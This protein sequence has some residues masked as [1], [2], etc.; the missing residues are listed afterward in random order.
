MTTSTP[1]YTW[2]SVLAMVSAPTQDETE[3][4]AVEIPHADLMERGSQIR[5]EKIL[6]DLVRFGG[7]VGEFWPKATPAQKR[8]L[9]GFSEPLLKVFVHEGKKLAD[10]VAQFDGATDAREASRAAAIAVA[11][12]AYRDGMEERDRLVTALDGVSHLE[13]G[14]DERVTKATGRVT[15]F[16]TLAQSLTSLLKVAKDIR[17]NPLS[18]AAK[19]LEDGGLDTAQII[20]FEDMAAKVKS[21]GELASGARTKG[22]IT[23]A[24]LD[25]QDGI[26]LSQMER[27]MKVFNR[28]HERDPSIPRLTP[29]ATRRLFVSSRKRAEDAPAQ[30]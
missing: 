7:I 18:K 14:L 8:H 25:L 16:T 29:I 28:A 10:M 2:A 22:P 19:Q 11:D 24:D 9:L 13:P 27:V 5:S 3:R 12:Q 6:T 4:Y 20:A 30:G 15:D 23:Q 17:Q 21:T 26:C 1:T